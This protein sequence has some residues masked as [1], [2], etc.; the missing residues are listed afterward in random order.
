MFEKVGYTEEILINASYPRK[1]ISDDNQISL[2]TLLQ[3]KEKGETFYSLLDKEKGDIVKSFRIQT[4]DNL[5]KN[6]LGNKN[7]IVSL[8]NKAERFLEQIMSNITK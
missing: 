3:E 1:R 7:F 6:F 4:I 2:S 5:G 8:E